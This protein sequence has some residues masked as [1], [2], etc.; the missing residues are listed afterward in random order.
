MF[1]DGKGETEP[2]ST[3]DTEFGRQTNRRIEVAICVSVAAGEG[4]R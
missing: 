2:V 1:M 3:N 4:S